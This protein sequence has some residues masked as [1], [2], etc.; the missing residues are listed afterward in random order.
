MATELSILKPCP[1][2]G[3]DA[4]LRQRYEPYIRFT[5]CCGICKLGLPWRVSKARV[6]EQW[7]R[8]T[9]V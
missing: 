6:V 1:C 4:E 5:V 7:N 3:H 9:H 2:C 8:R